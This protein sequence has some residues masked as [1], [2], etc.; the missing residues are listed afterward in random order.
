MDNLIGYIIGS[1]IIVMALIYSIREVRKSIKGGGCSGCPNA[2][3]N[4]EKK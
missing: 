4:K 1:V 2:T 3:K